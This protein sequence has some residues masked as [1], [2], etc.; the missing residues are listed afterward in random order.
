[1]DA[2]AVRPGILD[3]EP[4]LVRLFTVRALGHYRYA[5]GKRGLVVTSDR[6]FRGGWRPG[7]L[8]LVAADVSG[9]ALLLEDIVGRRARGVLQETAFCA[10]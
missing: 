1:M 3:S 5:A 10:A 2:S 6:L 9:A 7:R 4:A 8:R